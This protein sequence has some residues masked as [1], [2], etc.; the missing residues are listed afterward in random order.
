MEREWMTNFINECELIDSFRFF[1]NQPDNYTWWSYRQNSRLKNKGWRLDYNFA[2]YTLK[3]KLTRAV[4][5]KEAVHSD[6]CPALLEFD[7]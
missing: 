4:I 3:E 1:N 2:S 6:H 7:M 5:L